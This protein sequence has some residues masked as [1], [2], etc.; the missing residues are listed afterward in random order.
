MFK[1]F[2]HQ[3]HC[4]PFPH[5]VNVVINYDLPSLDAKDDASEADKASAYE[6]SVDQYLHRVGR[7]GRFGTKGLAITFVSS[8]EDA[9][10]LNKVRA[11]LPFLEFFLVFCL[12]TLEDKFLGLVN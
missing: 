3:P 1:I 9:A 8:P 6:R 5:Q 11:L 7:A 10:I 2:H 4:P 12:E